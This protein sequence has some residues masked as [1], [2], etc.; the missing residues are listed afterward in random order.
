[1]EVSEN[2][3]PRITQIISTRLR[4]K[5]SGDCLQFASAQATSSAAHP[6]PSPKMTRVLATTWRT[7]VETL[8]GRNEDGTP[9]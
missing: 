6:I 2:I 4:M 1:M 7:T 9:S 8:D 5:N 3:T